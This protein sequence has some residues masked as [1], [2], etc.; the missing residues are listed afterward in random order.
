MK[1]DRPK[2]NYTFVNPNTPREVQEMLKAMIVEKLLA[3][4]TGK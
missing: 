2:V 1:Q 4:K 3:E